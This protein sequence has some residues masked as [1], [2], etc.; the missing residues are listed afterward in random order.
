MNTR[1]AL[2][3][4]PN[5]GK[6]TV[7]NALTGSRQHVGNWPGKTVEKNEGHYTYDGVKYTVTDLP[8]SYGLTGNSDE[9][10]I[11]ADYIKSGNADLV[12]ILADASQLE[13]SMYMTAEFAPLQKPAVL[14]LNMMDVAKAQQKEINHKLLSERLGIPVLPFTAAESKG[15]GELKKLLAQELAQPHIIS[16]APDVSRENPDDSTADGVKSDSGAKYEWIGKMLDGVTTSAQKEYKLSAF[17]R[18][19]TAPFWGKLLSIGII[20]LA[21]LV[22]MIICIPFMGIGSMLPSLLGQPIADTLSGWNVHPWLVSIFSLIIPNVLYFSLSMAAFVLGVNIVFGFLEEIG[23][24]ARA[25]Y[26]F[27]SVLSKLGLQGKAICPMLMGFG[28]TIGG[29]CG[30]RVM[31][32]WGQRML[33]MAVV[34]A[35]PCGSIWSVIPVISSMFFTPIETLLVCLGI[36]VYMICMMWLVSKV[37]GRVLSPKESRTG[38][39]MELPPYHKAHWGH[40]LK[41]SFL[42]AFDIF[43]RALSTVT[44]VSLLFWVFSFSTTGNVQD[45]LLY[46]VGTF[47][48]PVTRF[49]GMG[50]QTF[51]GFLSSAFA[52]EAVLGV[53]NAIFVGQNSLVEAT[54]HAGNTATDGAVLSQMMSQTVSKPEALA[55]MAAC[56]FNIPCVMA[57]TTTY[58]ESHSF[59]WTARVALFYIGMA[60]LLSC[61]VYHIA[62]LFM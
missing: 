33:A 49:F 5:S 27:D 48:E 39:I 21:F 40:I 45:S 43:K 42:K 53:L 47:I 20:L 24:L 3:G 19:A 31:D 59:K 58:R 6:S 22:A 28:C 62:A 50:W 17:D 54:F 44:I 1:I 51:M 4:Q 25:A 13:R 7:Y 35:V 15:Y 14:L 36:L 12:C 8:G 16:S 46:Q 29:T 52:K 61:V 55:F 18:I 2:L 56:T 41:E 37:F 57:L 38:M 23:F 60:L 9:E 10:V 11:T 34:W 30:T 32:N 26:Q